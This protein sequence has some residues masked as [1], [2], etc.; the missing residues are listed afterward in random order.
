[1]ECHPGERLPRELVHGFRPVAR[2]VDPDFAH[3][4]NGFRTHVAGFGAGARDLKRR[5]SIVSKQAFCHLA[6]SGVSCAEDQNSRCSSPISKVSNLHVKKS[7]A[8]AQKNCSRLR[9]FEVLPDGESF[10]QFFANREVVAA[11]EPPIK[12]CLGFLDIR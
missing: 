6:S 4:G 10:P 8:N 7:P 5:A 1:M 2:D 9:W 11:A 3:G 12:N